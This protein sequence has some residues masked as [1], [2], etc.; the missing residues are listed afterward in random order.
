M[1]TNLIRAAFA[2]VLVA[3]PLAPFAGGISGGNANS[4]WTIYAY[5]NYSY[6]WVESENYYG[7]GDDRDMSRISA[8][9]AHLGFDAQ[10]D[11]GFTVGETPIIATFRCEQFLFINRLTGSGIFG[12][13]DFCNR[14]SKLGLAGVW[15]EVM[16]AHWL[17]PHNEM[18][19][20]W[21]DPFG[22]AGADSTSSIMGS[23]GFGTRFFNGGFGFDNGGGFGGPTNFGPFGANFGP[24]NNG[25]N[26][27]QNGVVQWFSPNWNGFTARI[28]TSNAHNDPGLNYFSGNGDV[29]VT[30]ASGTTKKID[31]RIWSMGVAYE[32]DVGKGR[33]TIW[34]ALTYEKHDDWAAADFGCR[35]SDDDSWRI[36]GRYIH[37]W[38]NGHSTWFSGMYEEIKYVHK[39]CATGAGILGGNGVAGNR[40]E[41]ERDAWMISGKH[42]FPGPFDIRF[43]YMDADD[44]DC[45]SGAG[46]STCNNGLSDSSSSGDA[47]NIGLFYTFPAGTE[48]RVI[49]SEV[50]NDRNANYDFG[51]N[52]AG[53]GVGGD[54]EMV[55]VGLVQL[56]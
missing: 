40:N 12:F 33:S 24:Q 7:P 42:N 53:N 46:S 17:L 18:V 5:Q 34:G 52:S 28:A 51:I 15:G 27:R 39:D 6:E 55:A 16:F 48:L 9:V 22:D 32:N 23:V 26:R 13:N 41:V 38:G 29:Q 36:A 19:F 21:I 47:Y 2:F 35:D 37:D 14:N 49:Y 10:I 20:P 8:N 4:N 11:T 45:D 31:P 25:F 54:L 56:F 50:S 3:L 44:L 1:K 30:T 43:S